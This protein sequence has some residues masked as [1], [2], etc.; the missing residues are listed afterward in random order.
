MDLGVYDERRFAPAV[1]EWR[2]GHSR[3]PT[4]EMRRHQ[5]QEQDR[6]DLIRLL[7]KECWTAR[8]ISQWLGVG[9]HWVLGVIGE[10]AE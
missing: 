5:Q 9:L 6:R 7:W 8:E 1:R 2:G 4:E 3:G 10:A